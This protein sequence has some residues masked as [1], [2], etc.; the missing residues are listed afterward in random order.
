MFIL[1]SWIFIIVTKVKLNNLVPI[2][3]GL[4]VTTAIIFIA[5]Y[6][7][8]GINPARD[9]GPRVLSFI[10]GWK[11]VA[12]SQSAILDYILGPLLGGVIGFGIYIWKKK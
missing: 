3:I 6:T 5:P 1:S 7:Q 8:C 9:F 10:S 2:L 4:V 12:F 11:N